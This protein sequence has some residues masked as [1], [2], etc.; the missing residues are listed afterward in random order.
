MTKNLAS[1]DRALR[2]G[3]GVALGVAAFAA[4]IDWRLRVGLLGA[5]AV[6]LLFTALSGTCVGYRLLGMSSCPRTPQQ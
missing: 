1:W 2:L 3:V 6:Y 5:N 4:S